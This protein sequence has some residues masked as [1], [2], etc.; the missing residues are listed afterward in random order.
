MGETETILFDQKIKYLR[1]PLKRL[2]RCQF[3]VPFGWENDK[4]IFFLSDPLHSNPSDQNKNLGSGTK[5]LMP[6]NG[7]DFWSYSIRVDP[8][9]NILGRIFKLEHPPDLRFKRFYWVLTIFMTLVTR[10]YL[11]NMPPTE[12]IPF[13]SSKFI[14]RV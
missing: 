14:S 6:G 3:H 2:Q 4:I 12:K 8:K 7:S 9:T 5:R 13:M 1:F 10:P 11:V